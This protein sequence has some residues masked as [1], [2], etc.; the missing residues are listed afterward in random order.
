MNNVAYIHKTQTSHISQTPKQNLQSPGM[1]GRECASSS[2]PAV[3]GVCQ[4]SHLT[5]CSSVA[6]HCSTAFF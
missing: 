1:L 2:L 5:A 6:L 4:I 3:F